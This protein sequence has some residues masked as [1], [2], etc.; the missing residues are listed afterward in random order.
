MSVDG[1]SAA[2]NFFRKDL[3]SRWVEYA[4]QEDVLRQ[5]VPDEVKQDIE[6]L[7]LSREVAIR[8]LDL[9]DSLY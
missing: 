9:L 7:G 2:L 5:D 3:M 6:R 1:M 8:C 4:G